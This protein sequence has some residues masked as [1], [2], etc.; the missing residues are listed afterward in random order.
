MN[1]NQ[2][3]IDFIIDHLQDEKQILLVKKIM[4]KID[5]VLKNYSIEYTNFL[6]PYNREIC[7]SVINR[8]IDVSYHEDGGFPPAERKSIILYPNY[9]EKSDTNDNLTVLKIN[10]KFKLNR[11]THRDILGAILGLGINR[12]KIGDIIVKDNYCQ[13]IVLSDISSYIELNLNKIGKTNVKIEIINRNEITD[14]DE[15]FEEKVIIA[16]SLRLD[17][18]ISS[19]INLSR[20]KCV[21]IIKSAKVKVNYKSITTSSKEIKENDLIS[22]RGKGRFRV[23]KILGYTK[24]NNTKILI[25]KY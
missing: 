17:A 4:D 1:K 8:F 6:D 9:F 13:V 18:I 23:I 11:I 12:D 14:N 10:G 19:V 16:A 20:V 24:K 22:L 2:K 15:I 7:C 21:N 25:R 3:N 5:K